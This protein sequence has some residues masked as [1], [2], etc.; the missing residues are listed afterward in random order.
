MIPS[1]ISFLLK[2]LRLSWPQ[3]PLSAYIF[4]GFS[5]PCIPFTATTWKKF[6]SIRLTLSCCHTTRTANILT[7]DGQD[8]HRCLLFLVPRLAGGETISL[9]RGYFVSLKDDILCSASRRNTNVILHPWQSVDISGEILFSFHRFNFET[10]KMSQTHFFNQVLQI[11]KA[12]NRLQA[13]LESIHISAI[14]FIN[15]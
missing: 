8:S 2:N 11:P 13:P 6:V 15:C 9:F 5:F 7:T 1:A 10:V 14:A 12:P 3:Y 4:G